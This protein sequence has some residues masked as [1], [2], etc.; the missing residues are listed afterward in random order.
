MSFKNNAAKA[1]LASPHCTADV[2]SAKNGYGQTAL[3]FAA[4]AGHTAIVDAILASPH[5]TAELLSAKN[6]YG[7]T[8][9]QLAARSENPEL[10][11][12]TVRYR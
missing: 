5:C 12:A 4:N 6:I 8:A 2:L 3:H 1:I 9:L 7:K 11:N 10:I